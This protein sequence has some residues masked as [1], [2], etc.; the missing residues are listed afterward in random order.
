MP[1]YNSKLRLLYHD[2]YWPLP[3][4]DPGSQIDQQLAVPPQ[5]LQGITGDLWSYE[6]LETNQKPVAYGE[7]KIIFEDHGG[8]TRKTQRWFFINQTQND[9]TNRHGFNLPMGMFTNDGVDIK[10][11]CPMD[12]VVP[13]LTWWSSKI[14]NQFSA[15]RASHKF[16]LVGI[17]YYIK[18]TIWLF[19]IAMENHQF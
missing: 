12:Q 19:N 9:W 16:P 2:Y 14:S 4:Q 11:W 1:L 17:K 13:S 18:I 15:C 10:L 6:V 5:L 8:Y 3:A 7:Q